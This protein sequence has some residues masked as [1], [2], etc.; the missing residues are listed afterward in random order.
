MEQVLFTMLLEKLDI[1]FAVARAG[2]ISAQEDDIIDD[3]KIQIESKA[4]LVRQQGM[5]AAGAIMGPIMAKYRG[6][7]SGER[8]S[9]L[10]E[11]TLRSFLASRTDV[12]G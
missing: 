11:D 2:L 12:V 10:V 1:D 9:Q 8:I 5:R 3:I 4:H 7:A 6:R